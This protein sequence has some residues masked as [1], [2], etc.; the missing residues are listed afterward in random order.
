MGM[1]NDELGMDAVGRLTVRLEQA[2]P[3]D[4]GITNTSSTSTTQ[5]APAAP[6]APASTD[7][8]AQAPV[9]SGST[10]ATP[11]S[12]TDG[13]QVKTAT[14]PGVTNAS[15]QFQAYAQ[16]NDMFSDPSLGGPDNQGASE[17]DGENAINDIQTQYVAPLDQA[18]KAVEEKETELATDLT[19]FGSTLTDEQRKAFIDNFKAK[20]KDVYDARD[21]AQADLA[22]ALKD[23]EPALVAAYSQTD[24]LTGTELAARQQTIMGLFKPL[25]K[26]PDGLVAVKFTQD[27]MK[28]PQTA[29]NVVKAG[30]PSPN[31]FQK[32][33]QSLATDVA[34]PNLQVAALKLAQE[35]GISPGEA[36]A[37]L[38][39]GMQEAVDKFTENAKE[40][41]PTPE[42][43]GLSPEAIAEAR[44][45]GSVVRDT[46][47]SLQKLAKGTTQIADAI[48]KSQLSGQKLQQV[49]GEMSE[50]EAKGPLGKA[51]IGMAVLTAPFAMKKSL[52]EGDVAGALS[53]AGFSAGDAAELLGKS[54]LAAR[55]F[56]EGLETVMKKAGPLATSIGAV[57]AGVDDFM[58]FHKDGDAGHIVAGVGQFIVA[59]G[60]L[61]A[62]IFPP[63]AAIAGIAIGVGTIA[64][65][66][67]DAT[68]GWRKDEKDKQE[69]AELL[70]QAK[71]D[72]HT[73]DLIAHADGS[74]LKRITSAPPDGLGQSGFAFQSL[75][76][77]RPELES[78][79]APG[80][81]LQGL[82]NFAGTNLVPKNAAD[83]DTQ[84]LVFNLLAGAGDHAANPKDP[85]QRDESVK[86]LLSFLTGSG[87]QLGQNPQD[88]LAHLNDPAW[89]AANAGGLDHA[90]LAYLRQT[91]ASWQQT[92]QI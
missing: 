65:V 60:V 9:S 52:D 21:K 43:S 53:A 29:A 78:L 10:V 81:D 57:A 16:G 13:N 1:I 90:T 58:K 20:N 87:S 44:E 61:A 38:G 85:V 33:L 92:G 42:E 4:V 75:L 6:T 89:V 68:V 26:T 17:K 76:K 28:N 56:G 63:G 14:V 23:N 88:T 27:V 54:E 91:L 40:A 3:F 55:A 36:M 41:P 11:A 86:S 72:P 73:A 51:L 74:Q 15:T 24:H 77:D 48:E 79:L 84:T 2:C 37:Q 8:P 67:A 7:T 49:L 71:V 47:E 19:R 31:I 69:L 50:E 12:T 46:V 64:S 35:K 30:G 34:A 18:Q 32:N 25:A 39:G 5:A 59:T 22:K 82:I 66:V 80:T 45:Q 62:A 83:T 70:T